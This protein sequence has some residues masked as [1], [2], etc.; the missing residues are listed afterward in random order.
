MSRL[1][2]IYS[3]IDDIGTDMI[4]PAIVNIG[5]MTYIHPTAVIGSE[6]FGYEWDGNGWLH[7]PHRGDVRIGK[8]VYIGPNVCVARATMPGVETIIGDGT[9]ID[10]LSY[11]AHNVVIGEHCLIGSNVSIAGSCVVGNRVK[12]W[13]NT[14][15][16]KKITIGDGAEIANGSVIRRNVGSNEIWAGN[17][18]KLI[19]RYEDT[20][21][22]TA[23]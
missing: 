13:G 10:G 22:I 4:L 17:P 9:K 11:I 7:F 16:S 20:G 6:G 12:I 14:S 2:F 18:A 3:V 8:M 21:I 5:A 23:P 1:D 19:G 15:I